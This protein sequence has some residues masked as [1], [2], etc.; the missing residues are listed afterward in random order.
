MFQALASV[1]SVREKLKWRL[2]SRDVVCRG[3]GKGLVVGGNIHMHEG[4]ISRREI[5][6]LPEAKQKQ[7]Y[8]E[9]NCVLLCADCNLNHPPTRDKIWKSQYKL[10]GDKL[11]EWHK[12]VSSLFKVPIQRFY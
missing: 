11:I 4:I 9:Y 8:N 12:G 6:G 1:S 5:M 10:Y 7:F 3:C 2:L